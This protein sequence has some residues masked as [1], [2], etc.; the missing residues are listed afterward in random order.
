MRKKVLYDTIQ[1]YEARF[2]ELNK[3]ISALSVSSFQV[4]EINPII[5]NSTEYIDVLLSRDMV[6]ACNR[7]ITD[8]PDLD[9]PS[10]KLEYMWYCYGALCFFRYKG[11]PKIGTFAKSGSLNGIGDLKEIIPIDFAGHSYDTKCNVVY[12]RNVTPNAAVIIGDYTGTYREDHIIPRKTLNLVSISDQAMVYK[13]LRNAILITA[14]KAIALLENPSQ[15]EELERELTN[16]LVND[17][18]VCSIV[19]DSLSEI[20]KIFNID[21]KVEIDPYIRAIE[22]YERIRANFNGI[23]TRSPLDK[24]ERLITSEAENDNCVT[25][26][27]LYDG[28][29][30]RKIGLDL[31]VEHKLISSYSLKIN[32]KLEEKDVRKTSV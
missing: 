12:N 32:P 21:T 8:I 5:R 31:C 30:N 1:G 17:S 28:Y 18:P 13:R 7:Y 14:R 3:Q 6:E 16:V 9:I 15:K 19:S 2:K 23:K 11:E 22:S 20:C 10:N 29:I 26:I 25:E 27:M 4:S 24:K